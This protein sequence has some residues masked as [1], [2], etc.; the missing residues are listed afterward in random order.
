[1]FLVSFMF[2]LFAGT[3]KVVVLVFLALLTADY[4]NQKIA[5]AEETI[6]NLSWEQIEPQLMAFGSAA[7]AK[8]KTETGKLISSFNSKDGSLHKTFS[9]IRQTGTDQSKNFWSR[10]LPG[11]KSPASVN[12]SSYRF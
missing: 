3:F 5:E 11:P 2:R 12:R 8:A 7:Y 6:A 10:G 9:A 1:M 4:A